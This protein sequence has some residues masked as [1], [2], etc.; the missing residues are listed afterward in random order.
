MPQTLTRPPKARPAKRTAEPDWSVDDVE[1]VVLED[2]SW[3][4][5]TQLLQNI[6][7]RNIRISYDNGRLEMMSPLPEHEEVSLLVHDLIKA[8]VAELE[9]EVKSLGSTTFR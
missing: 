9:M 8:L 3:E 5:Y 6:G 1:H 2:A 7:N 4:L